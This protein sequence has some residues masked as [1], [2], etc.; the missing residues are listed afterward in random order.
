MNAELQEGISNGVQGTPAFFVN[1]QFISGAQPYS[2]FK[3]VIDSQL[4]G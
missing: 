1:G 2:A 3:Q 4:A